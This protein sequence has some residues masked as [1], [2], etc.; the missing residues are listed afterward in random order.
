MSIA[1]LQIRP[2]PSYRRTAFEQGLRRLGYS[3]IREYRAGRDWPSGQGDLLVVWNLHR[4]PDE[5]YAQQWEARGGTVVV[6]ENGY[7][8]RE[9][10]TYFAISTHGHNGSGWFPIL[11]DGAQRF[12]RIGFEIKPMREGAMREPLLT[13][14]ILVRDQRGIGSA[15][16]ASP[17]RWG[18][19]MARMLRAKGYCNVTLMAHPGDRGKL[20]RDEAA[21]RNAD[22]VYIW[23]SAIGV[24][25]LVEGI[26]VVH[27][28][29][30]WICAGWEI[31]G[32]EWALH[33]MACGQWHHEEIA[34]GEPFARMRDEGWGRKGA[35]SIKAP[36]K[37]LA[38]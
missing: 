2:Q 21:L 16:M 25:A 32:R 4:G 35:G 38:A 29:P 22:R 7:L 8:Q 19:N 18:D 9:D 20:E 23:S 6:C 10:K 33:T 1:V 31:A 26:P 13:D 28:A 37:E 14:R 15:L 34:R 24:R 5:R 11:D 27:H 12:E 36:T 17:R 30:H 3:D